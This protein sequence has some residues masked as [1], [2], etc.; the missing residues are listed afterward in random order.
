MTAGEGCLTFNMRPFAPALKLPVKRQS[1]TVKQLQIELWNQLRNPSEAYSNKAMLDV[2]RKKKKKKGLR[3]FF[4][5]KIIA[6]IKSHHSVGS[7]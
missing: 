1:F 2:Y 5:I 7:E 3:V 4:I 6:I